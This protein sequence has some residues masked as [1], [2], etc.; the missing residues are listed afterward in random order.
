MKT[1][2]L[3]DYPSN[4]TAIQRYPLLMWEFLRYYEG[5]RTGVGFV[6]NERFCAWIH[7][8]KVNKEFK[9]TENF[10]FLYY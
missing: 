1:R 9:I 3:R 7:C 4:P 10:H 5:V 6:S 8:R 2:G